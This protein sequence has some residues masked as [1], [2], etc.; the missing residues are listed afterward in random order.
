MTTILDLSSKIAPLSVQI[1]TI[2]VS[3]NSVISSLPPGYS[4]EIEEGEEERAEGG[5]IFEELDHL[6]VILLFFFFCSKKKK[7][8]N[9]LG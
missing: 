1:A 8:I 9:F 2:K 6:T 5:S 3:L 7:K 4:M